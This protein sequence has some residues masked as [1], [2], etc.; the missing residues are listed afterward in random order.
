MRAS[1]TV[2]NIGLI[3]MCGLI[4][5]LGIS[6]QENPTKNRERIAKAEKESKKSG[7]RAGDEEI[8][9]LDAPESVELQAEQADK[10][11]DE[12]NFA[13]RRSDRRRSSD[14]SVL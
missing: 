7:D 8:K 11:D 13:A 3:I 1:K 4:F 9:K 6:A 10:K 5:A 14:Y 12:K 2:K